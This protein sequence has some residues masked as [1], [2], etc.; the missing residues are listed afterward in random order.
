MCQVTDKRIVELSANFFFQTSG[1]T[2]ISNEIFILEFHEMFYDI[3]D[4]S[5]LC[6]SDEALTE[7]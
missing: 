2:F 7:S 6:L 4:H 5:I 1:P 3:K